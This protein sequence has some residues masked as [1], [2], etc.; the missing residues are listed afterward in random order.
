MRI[1]KF[2]MYYNLLERWL[3]VHEEGRTLSDIL[4]QREIFTIALYGMGKIG[5][6]VINELKG[7]SITVVYA[8]DRVKSGLYDSIVVKRIDDTLPK[9]DA[10]LVAAVY[11]FDEIEETLRKY[12]TYPIISLEEILYEG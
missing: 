10:V 7:S 12:V 4:A 6:H 11:D 1:G 9:V 8:I 2:E 3:T 5:K